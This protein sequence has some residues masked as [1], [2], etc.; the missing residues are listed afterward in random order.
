[1]ITGA[2]LN[3]LTG[4]VTLL[5]RKNY[6]AANLSGFC[7]GL[8]MCF[9]MSVVWGAIPDTADFIFSKKGINVNGFLMAFISVGCAAGTGVCGFISSCILDF[10]GYVSTAVTQASTVGV[11]IYWAFGG[12]PVIFGLLMVVFAAMFGLKTRA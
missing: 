8:S 1:M 5:A 7:M 9:V 6:F 2:L 4:V 11:G 10:V 3:V 12:A